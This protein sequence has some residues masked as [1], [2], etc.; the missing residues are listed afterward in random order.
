[1]VS[2]SAQA[3]EK[4]ITNGFEGYDMQAWDSLTGGDGLTGFE[5]GGGA[6]RSGRVNGW[7]STTQGW[8]REG[9]WARFGTNIWNTTMCTAEIYVKPDQ[10]LQFE[11][12]VWNPQGVKL[13]TNAP[14]L[15]ANG[16]YQLVRVTWHAESNNNAFVEAILG[17]DR[18][19]R[20]VRLDDLVV[21]CNN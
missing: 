21:R 17:S 15:V 9:T 4:V 16:N 14:W 20:A 7:L 1:M 10:D 5:N 6:A 18:A 19:P 11:L 13:A 2:P 8:A 3:E 12:R